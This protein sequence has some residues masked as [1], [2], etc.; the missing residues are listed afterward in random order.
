MSGW[1]GFQDARKE[2][3]HRLLALIAQK[4]PMKAD[5]LAALFSLKTGIT[6]KRVHE[7]LRDLQAAGAIKLNPQVEITSFGKTVLEG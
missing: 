5:R 4:G 2:R 7:Y 6:T 1:K 3:V